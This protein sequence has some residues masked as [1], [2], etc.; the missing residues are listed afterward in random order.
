MDDERGPKDCGNGKEDN[1]GH[2]LTLGSSHEAPNV[3]GVT[4]A[5]YPRLRFAIGVVHV[6]HLRQLRNVQPLAFM[7]NAPARLGGFPLFDA[8]LLV[9]VADAAGAIL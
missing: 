1:V 2:G 4:F 5:E 8:N 9:V 3:G 7:E 6:G